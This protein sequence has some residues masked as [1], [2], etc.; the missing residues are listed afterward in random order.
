[1]TALCL[2]NLLLTPKMTLAIKPSKGISKVCKIQQHLCEFST[3]FGS[4]AARE[5]VGWGQGRGGMLQRP[6]LGH[7]ATHPARTVMLA[8]GS[9]W[10][11]QCLPSLP[12]LLSLE[13]EEEGEGKSVEPEP[14]HK[15]GQGRLRRA[16][17]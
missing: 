9:P 7:A 2:C 17:L 12:I 14:Q 1:M 11:A 15:A 6:A 8:V 16:E 5:T 10:K 13:G 4:E 3:F